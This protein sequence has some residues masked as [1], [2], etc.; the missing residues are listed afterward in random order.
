MITG[1]LLARTLD[2]DGRG[3]LSIIVTYAT[4]ISTLSSFSI[5][6]AIVKKNDKEL[7][8]F[9]ASFLDEIILGLF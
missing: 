8:L 3:E 4:L 9:T 2:S 1:I 5:P 7:N 6:E